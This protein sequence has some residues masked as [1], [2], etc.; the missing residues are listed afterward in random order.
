MQRDGRERAWQCVE[1]IQCIQGASDP[2][3]SMMMKVGVWPRGR[4][5]QTPFTVAASLRPR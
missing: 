4:T 5:R 1:I 2:L 3:S